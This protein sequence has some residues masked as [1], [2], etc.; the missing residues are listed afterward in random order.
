MKNGESSMKSITLLTL[1]I[2]IGCILATGC[3]AQP[4]KDPVNVT[5]SPTVT[6][7]PFV[8]T[9]TAPVIN[10]TNTTNTTGI[11]ATSKLTGPLRVSIS[12]YNAGIPLPVLIDNVTVGNVSADKPLDVAVSEG[13]HTV[14]VCVG[15]ICPSRPVD[16][17]F[18]KKSFLDFGEELRKQVE[19]PTPT[20]RMI[21]YFKNGNGVGVNIEYINPT[22]KDLAMSAEV[23]CGYTYIDSRT[24]LRMGDSVRVKSSEYVEAGK[25]VTSTVNLYFAY[26]SA[27]T[28][29]EPAIKE[30]TYE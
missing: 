21:N 6:F 20:V 15:V 23:S 22:Q 13:N 29:D 9:T 11:N 24:S 12:G 30:I 26:G 2:A 27:Y 3:V 1:L 4:K 8:N 7:I 5:A 10:V 18:A 16:I 28:F 17:I 14:K 25:R 19:F